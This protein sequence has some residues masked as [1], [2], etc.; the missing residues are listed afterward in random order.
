MSAC[1][2]GEYS[3]LGEN[4]CTEEDYVFASDME[5][6]M[7]ADLDQTYESPDSDG[8]QFQCAVSS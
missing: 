6:F 3:L 7:C 4:T 8:N 2:P 5:G 1:N